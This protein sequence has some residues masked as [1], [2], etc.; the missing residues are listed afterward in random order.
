MLDSEWAGKARLISSI[1]MRLGLS[2]DFQNNLK[3]NEGL[4]H[5]QLNPKDFYFT[6]T[7]YIPV[8]ENLEEIPRE[9]VGPL[10]VGSGDFI[11]GALL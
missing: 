9:V 8:D 3:Q 11:K 4:I 2:W 7:D 6:S 5:S 1:L 10:R